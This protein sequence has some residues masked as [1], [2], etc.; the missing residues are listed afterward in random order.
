MA[1][2]KCYRL[3]LKT[4][5]GLSQP[6]ADL[7]I[8]IIYMFKFFKWVFNMSRPSLVHNLSHHI[9]IIAT[10]YVQGDLI[11]DPVCEIQAEVV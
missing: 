10:R 6:K 2:I 11:S 5:L 4:A 8:P 9:I 7:L 3:G 1:A